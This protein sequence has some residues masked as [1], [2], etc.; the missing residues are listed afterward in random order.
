M[1]KMKDIEGNELNVGDEVYYARKR[2]YHANGELIK[3][4]ITK[5][6][7]EVVYMG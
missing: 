4:K 3:T 7:D 1:L 2:D 6:A 5:I